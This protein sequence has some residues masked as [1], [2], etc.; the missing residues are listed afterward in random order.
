LRRHYLTLA[1]A[2][3]VPVFV[4]H[5][6]DATGLDLG[7]DLV[8]ELVSH[9]NVWGFKDSA[10]VG[11]PL[12]DTLQRT[13]TIGFVGH[14]A[15]LLEGLAAGA[16]GGILAVAHLIPEMCMRVEACWRA[17]D[18]DAAAEAQRHVTAV[19]HAMRSWTV[20]GVKY[21][22]AWRGLPGGV[23]RRPLAPP[24]PDIEERIAAALSAALAHPLDT[25][26]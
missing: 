26:S 13:R 16:A 1:D 9:P 22:L 12:A 5:M 11:G 17:G 24:P 10:V 7:A 18:S 2:A 21:G 23:P 14:G 6:P 8:V 19:T 4:Y 20:P 15:R 3:S 25:R